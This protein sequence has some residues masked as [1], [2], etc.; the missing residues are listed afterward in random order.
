[1]CTSTASI[2]PCTSCRQPW[3]GQHSSYA[4]PGEAKSRPTRGD[5]I[6][7][8]ASCFQAP[9]AGFGGA[10]QG[11]LPLVSYPPRSGCQLI[12]RGTTSL[13]V[14]RNARREE[15]VIKGWGCGVCRAA[16]T[17]KTHGIQEREYVDSRK[18]YAS[19]WYRLSLGYSENSVPSNEREKKKCKM[20]TTSVL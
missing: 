8:P 5:A 11:L 12:M 17:H 14:F 2:K 13:E 15:Q 18:K 6:V 10:R 1:V 7:V 16:K 4:I 9:S 19:S 20:T 3:N